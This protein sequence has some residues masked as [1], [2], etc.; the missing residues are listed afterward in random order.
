MLLYC[1]YVLCIQYFVT[2]A[3]SATVFVSFRSAA[4]FLFFRSYLSTSVAYCIAEFVSSSTA[5][6]NDT[7]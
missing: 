5:S 1:M 6:E 2:L 7:R 4:P 3:C